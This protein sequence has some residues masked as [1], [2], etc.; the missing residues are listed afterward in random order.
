MSGQNAGGPAGTIAA[1]HE[2]PAGAVLAQ[3]AGGDDAPVRDGVP[4]TG[5]R[6]KSRSGTSGAERARRA[7]AAGGGTAAPSKPRAPRT[8]AKRPNIA[9]GMAQLYV[10]VGMGVSMIPGPPAVAGPGKAAGATV[11]GVVGHELVANSQSIGAAWEQAA[12]DDPRIREALEK[13]LSVSTFGL[14]AAA[15]LP[16]VLAGMVAAGTVAPE[17]VGLAPSGG[18]S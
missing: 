12:K 8:S 17:A 18:E 7:K 4:S 11:T 15:H 5:K 6:R 16:V 14:I 10:M 13:L 3:L 2:D 1:E 9:A